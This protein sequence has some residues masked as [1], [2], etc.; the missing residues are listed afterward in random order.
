MDVLDD[1]QEMHRGLV[2][3]QIGTLEL[4]EKLAAAQEIDIGETPIHKVMPSGVLIIIPE[5]PPRVD[6]FSRTE[7]RD[8]KIYSRTYRAAR[9]RWRS[10][11]KKAVEGYEGPR[12]EPA[13]VHIIYFVPKRCD[14]S[15]FIDKF[16]VDG[17]MDYGVTGIDD[18][19]EEVSYIGKR[20]RIDKEN[21]LT[22]IRV[23]KDDGSI[24]K[25]VLEK[26]PGSLSVTLRP[27][28][29]SLRG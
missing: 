14:I 26:L 22:E 28:E 20:V 1:F 16:I 3:T 4:M 9:D 21:P 6:V 13:L 12:I 10:L 29:D 11:I 24:D 15:N 8:G 19:Y 27:P 25:M 17:L 23:M 2:L 18:S 5:F 7:I